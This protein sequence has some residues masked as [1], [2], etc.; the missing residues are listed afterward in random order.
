MAE[1]PRRPPGGREGPLPGAREPPAAR[2][3]A[4]RSRTASAAMLS[5]ELADGRPDARRPRAPDAALVHAGREPGRRGEPGGPPGLDDP[6]LDDP[7]GAAARRDH[8]RRDPA[9][10]RHR[11][12]R[13][14]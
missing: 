3:R 13:R 10:D 6:R 9:L 5:F 14:T 11:G 2:A 4:A 8:R 1:L 12:P 7:G